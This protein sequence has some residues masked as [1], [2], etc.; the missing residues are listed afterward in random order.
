[1]D[2]EEIKDHVEA[3]GLQLIVIRFSDK[4]KLAFYSLDDAQAISKALD[5]GYKLKNKYPQNTPGVAIQINM[6]DEK[7]DFRS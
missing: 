5:M 3:A 6:G 7:K 2:D 4:G 1:M